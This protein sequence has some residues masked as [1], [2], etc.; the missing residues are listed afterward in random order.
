M[1][2]TSMLD[3]ERFPALDIALV[4]SVTICWAPRVERACRKCLRALEKAHSTS[5]D[6]AK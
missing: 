4:G 2:L 6:A 1:L 3:P 5:P